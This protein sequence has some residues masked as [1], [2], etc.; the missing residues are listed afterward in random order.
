MTDSAG[1][2]FDY[3]GIIFGAL[4]GCEMYRVTQNEQEKSEKNT[5]LVILQND[6]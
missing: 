6:N 3:F 4:C 5:E 2:K 1:D